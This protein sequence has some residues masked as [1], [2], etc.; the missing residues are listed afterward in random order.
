MIFGYKRGKILKCSKFSIRLTSE[1]LVLL[2]CFPM[3]WVVFVSREEIQTMILSTEW[4]LCHVGELRYGL[5]KFFGA[6]TKNSRKCIF[7]I[8][9]HP[10]ASKWYF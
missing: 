1:A 5:T 4:L 3:C 10:D 7:T 6:K 9:G 8:Y 2:L